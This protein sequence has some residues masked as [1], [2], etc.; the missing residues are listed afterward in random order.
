MLPLPPSVLNRP[1]PP[2]QKQRRSQIASR[3]KDCVNS[4]ITTLPRHF[5]RVL[6]GT[7]GF[8]KAVVDMASLRVPP[9][10]RAL[11]CGW[12][13]SEFGPIALK[14]VQRLA[15]CQFSE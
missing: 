10:F 12:A 14:L 4:D 9:G 5:R 11:Q 15:A 7:A 1:P 13:M 8:T 2:L 6:A 3:S